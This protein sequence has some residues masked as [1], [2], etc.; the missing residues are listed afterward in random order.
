[1]TLPKVGGSGS[2]GVVA[3]VKKQARKVEKL[4][5]DQ[6]AKEFQDAVRCYKQS[7]DFHNAKEKAVKLFKKSKKFREEV[8]QKA[9]EICNRKEKKEMRT[10]IEKKLKTTLR[11]YAE[12]FS[13]HE[14]FFR[15]VR[16]AKIS[17]IRNS[18]SPDSSF[19]LIKMI[20]KVKKDKKLREEVRHC[21]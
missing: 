14:P 7:E 2:G 18:E 11:Q 5:Q 3:P 21:P 6:R 4:L 1:M 12:L 9:L 13:I 10:A 17:W 16:G 8:K 19:M 15:N 20:K